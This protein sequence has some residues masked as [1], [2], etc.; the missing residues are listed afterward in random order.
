MWRPAAG[1]RPDF[2]ILLDRGL[3]QELLDEATG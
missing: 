3:G 1:G 2:G